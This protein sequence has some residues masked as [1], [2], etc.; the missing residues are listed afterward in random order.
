ML[1]TLYFNCL[2]SNHVTL[3]FVMP[4]RPIHE[5]HNRLLCA[6][7]ISS[8]HGT[9]RGPEACGLVPDIAALPQGKLP[10]GGRPL[11][12]PTDMPTPRSL[13]AIFFLGWANSGPIFPVDLDCHRNRVVRRRTMCLDS[14]CVRRHPQT[15]S[16][17]HNARMT[18]AKATPCH[19]KNEGPLLLPRPTLYSSFWL[20]EGRSAPQGQPTHSI[21]PPERT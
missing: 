1:Y 19:R 11:L 2:S 12:P 7:Q 13:P 8:R 3:Y 5:S 18:L 20:P 9:G 16:Q 15:L 21:P 6:V 10:R 14:G 4:S 17:F